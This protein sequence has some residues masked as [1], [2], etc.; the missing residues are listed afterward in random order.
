MLRD[1]ASLDWAPNNFVSAARPLMCELRSVGLNLLTST[2]FRGMVLCSLRVSAT[3]AGIGL[4]D[5]AHSFLQRQSFSG[6]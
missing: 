2:Q 3:L 5:L 6:S 1:T 4:S